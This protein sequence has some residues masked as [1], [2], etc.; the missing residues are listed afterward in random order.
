MSN[1]STIPKRR[2]QLIVGAW[3]MSAMV[4]PAKIDLKNGDISKT[5]RQ[6]VDL[7]AALRALRSMAR[8]LGQ[9]RAV[10]VHLQ[11]WG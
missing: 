1:K 7:L 9:R 2:L 8:S 4:E 5:T 6:D 3:V 11:H 10:R